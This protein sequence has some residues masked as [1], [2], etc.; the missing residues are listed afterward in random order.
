VAAVEFAV[1]L[2]LLFV[3]LFNALDA[4]KHF[5]QPAVFKVLESGESFSPQWSILSCLVITGGLLGLAAY[6]FKAA[7]Y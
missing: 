1:C 3:I 6:E 4:Q 7:D 5:G 2:P